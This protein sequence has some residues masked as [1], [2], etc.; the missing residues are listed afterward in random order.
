MCDSDGVYV[1][2]GVITKAELE[3]KALKGNLQTDVELELR[4]EIT[5]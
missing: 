1:D 2:V 5:R 3:E 4:N